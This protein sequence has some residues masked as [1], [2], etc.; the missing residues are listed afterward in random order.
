MVSVILLVLGIKLMEALNVESG[1]EDNVKAKGFYKATK[2]PSMKAS[3]L[4]IRE[5]DRATS[6]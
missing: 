1:T 3:G 6:N 2:G 4:Q 5:K